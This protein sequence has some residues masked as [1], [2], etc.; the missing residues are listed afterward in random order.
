M[1]IHIKYQHFELK[2]HVIFA[3]INEKKLPFWRIPESIRGPLDYETK[4]Y[5]TELSK[6]LRNLR[7]QLH[8]FFFGGGA[9]CLFV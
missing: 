6:Q 1:D 7:V 3:I 8:G 2:Q 9:V 5:P 4:P